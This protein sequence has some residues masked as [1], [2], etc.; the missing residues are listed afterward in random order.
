MSMNDFEGHTPLPGHEKLGRAIVDKNGFPS[1]SP[2]NYETLR[3]SSLA[4]IA[5]ET[6]TPTQADI[7][8][9]VGNVLA[10]MTEE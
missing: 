2:A 1:G 5:K 7:D 6:A 8:T 3:A 10:E 4:R 9:V